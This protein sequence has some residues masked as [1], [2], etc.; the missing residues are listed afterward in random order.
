M[1]YCVCETRNYHL[2]VSVYPWIY[3]NLMCALCNDVAIYIDDCIPTS[4]IKI[5][6]GGIP[7]T[8]L[9]GLHTVSSNV[10]HGEMCSPEQWLDLQVIFD[11]L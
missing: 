10:F 3:Q 1:K 5:P 2:H 7:L 4:G 9:L 8:F 6:G 11:V